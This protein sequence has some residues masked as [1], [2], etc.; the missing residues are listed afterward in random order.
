MHAATTANTTAGVQAVLHKCVHCCMQNTLC[1]FKL[2]SRAAQSAAA[3]I[4]YNNLWLQL[5]CR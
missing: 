2:A 1:L 5:P 4:Q 3:N